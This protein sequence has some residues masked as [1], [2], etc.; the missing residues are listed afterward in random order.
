[1]VRLR[2]ALV[3]PPV[4]VQRKKENLPDKGAPISG[5]QLQQQERKREG[6]GRAFSRLVVVTECNCFRFKKCIL[7]Y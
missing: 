3:V 6:G 7:Y 1:M 2:C 4:V 5:S